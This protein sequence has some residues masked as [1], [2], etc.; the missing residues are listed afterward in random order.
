VVDRLTA[1]KTGRADGLPYSMGRIERWDQKRFELDESA[2]RV[3]SESSL[4]VEILARQGSKFG[5]L[6]GLVSAEHGNELFV[7]I[8]RSGVVAGARFRFTRVI[9][10]NNRSF[11]PS[12]RFG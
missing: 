12:E 5:L 10:Q 11:R 7:V 9:L 4:F 2:V 3:A 1:D 6:R 8:G